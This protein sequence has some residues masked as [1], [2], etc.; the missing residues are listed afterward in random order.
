MLLTG[1]I[2]LWLSL[3]I[4]QIQT[5]EPEVCSPQDTHGWMDGQTLTNTSVCP[6]QALADNEKQ[7]KGDSVFGKRV[8]MYW[9]IS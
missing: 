5:I 4:K 3:C 6:E 1:S 2:G 7:L 8:L 9:Q